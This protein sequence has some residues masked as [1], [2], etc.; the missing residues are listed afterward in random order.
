MILI[1]FLILIFLSLAFFIWYHSKSAFI[2]NEIKTTWLYAFGLL[3]D[4]GTAYKCIKARFLEIITHFCRRIL[5][6]TEEIANSCSYWLVV[7]LCFRSAELLHHIAHF[8]RHITSTAAPDP[9]DFRI[10][11]PKRNSSSDGQEGQHQPL[12]FGQKT[13][14]FP[15]IIKKNVKI[16]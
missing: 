1:G 6:Q 2:K 11:L 4:Q 14:T 15:D 3:F 12:H 7:A 13:N 16:T 9:I 10:A 5:F 8:R